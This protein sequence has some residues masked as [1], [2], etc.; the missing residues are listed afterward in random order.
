MIA[1]WFVVLAVGILGTAVASRRAVNAA[2]QVVEATKFSPALVG[3]TVMSIGTDLPE[4]ANS[5]VATATDHGDVNVGDSMGSV[6]TQITLILGILCL[7]SPSIKAE[8]NFVISI[9]AASFFAAVV[10]WVFTQDGNLSRFDGAV[11]ILLWFGGTVLLGHEE[12]RP[13]SMAEK[14]G[15]AAPRNVVVTLFWLALVGAFAIAVIRSFLELAEAFSIPEFVGS[16]IAL[17]LGTS[18]PELAVDWTAIRRGASSMAIG[19]IFGACFV[20]STLSV[21][22]GPALF[23]SAVSD[24]VLLGVGLAAAAMAIATILVARSRRFDWRLGS[25][26]IAIYVSVQLVVVVS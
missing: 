13:N 2:L 24:D 26:L 12:L 15:T 8:R 19:G 11:L 1:V 22:I 7:A 20:D 6:L 4:I 14:R 16:F 5:I 17:S 9:G 23:G 3:L 10:V 18:L 25:T 21:G